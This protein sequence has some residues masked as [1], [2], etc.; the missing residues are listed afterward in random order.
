M[1]FSLKGRKGAKQSEKPE[2]TATGSDSAEPAASTSPAPGESATS[3][4]AASVSG[5]ALRLMLPGLLVLFLALMGGTLFLVDEQT[6]NDV[7]FLILFDEQQVLSQQIARDMAQ[8]QN[9]E[10]H[11]Y[12]LLRKGVQRY[13]GIL[14]IMQAGNPAIGL[15]ALPPEVRGPLQSMEKSWQTIRTGVTETLGHEQ[16][17]LS[18]NTQLGEF[19]GELA[20]IVQL[21]NQMAN[22]LVS[23]GADRAQ[24]QHSGHINTLFERIAGSL[25]TVAMVREGL[26]A[27][28]D[29]F[30]RENVLVGD[31]IN[32][33][34]VGDPSMG[35][36][37]VPD[38]NTRQM[39][40]KLARRF[41][42]QTD[43][44]GKIIET[45]VELFNIPEINHTILHDSDALLAS[46]QKLH[47]A[48][49]NWAEHRWVSA[50]L[51]MVFGGLALLCLI[52]LGIQMTRD[53]TARAQEARQREEEARKGEEAT[54]EVT[55]RSENAIL[56]LLDEIAALADGD[57]T[58]HATVTEE[59]TGT[60]ADAMNY[61]VETMRDLVTNIN[62]TAV[63]VAHAAEFTRGTAI[64][65]SS[66]SVKQAEEIAVTTKTIQSMATSAER[67]SNTAIQSSEVAKKSVAIANK[68]GQAVRDTIQGMDNIRENI[69]DT[70]KRIKRLGESSQEIG[71]IIGLIDD[72]ADQTNILALNAAIQASTAGEAG[73]GFA[74]VADEV[75][76]LAERAGQAT[77]QIEALV[78]TI[79]SDTN[80]A[81]SSMER[82]TEGVVSVAQQAEGA[83][84]SLKNIES[85]SQ[86]LA[87]LI[88]KM[89]EAS[90]EQSDQA[91]SVAQTM[92]GIQE[93]TDNTRKGTAETAK[94]VGSL[95][96]L[97]DSLRKSVAGFRLP[98]TG[99]DTVIGI[100]T[101]IPT[102]AE[103]GKDGQ[104]QL[105]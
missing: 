37:A 97:V 19:R 91:T 75:Q 80:E 85:V 77:K 104:A 70:S 105:G 3:V 21:S 43:N 95:A 9:A 4:E 16:R 1:K 25:H 58:T 53:A 94:S 42:G 6:G 8:V 89:S 76:R 73:R 90:Q 62:K 44:V 10:E 22:N 45:A 74:V 18:L 36:A 46:I 51:A 49:E 72:I 20:G 98:S 27:T 64:E 102:P 5:Q 78:K 23:T 39:L 68:G 12:A 31:M 35:V 55:R 67:V 29:G 86:H 93:V 59:I 99:E 2:A 33:L 41:R 101:S 65:L 71:D 40:E 103:N 92:S 69:Q 34:V 83:G 30:G 84:S 57:L 48:Y 96:D 61:A 50:V 47:G 87:A 32:A 60:I 82:S 63:E 26:V 24:I 14:K 15:P 13:D 54:R 66:A 79:Q 7:E 38:A 100:P 17:L 56:T 11:T 28:V 88:Q 52:A 81:V